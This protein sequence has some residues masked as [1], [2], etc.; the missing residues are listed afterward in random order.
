[1]GSS[2][3]SVLYINARQSSEFTLDHKG[4][5]LKYLLDVKRANYI[6]LILYFSIR[7]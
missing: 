1:V 5:F 3:D 4:A 6:L 7:V 2:V